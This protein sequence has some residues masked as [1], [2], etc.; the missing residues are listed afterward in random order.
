MA[1]LIVI[2]VG[3]VLANQFVLVRFPSI[4]PP[5][6]PG[7]RRQASLAVLSATTLVLALAAALAWLA[8]A[9]LL[10]PAGLLELRLLVIILSV[11]GVAAIVTPLL[12]RARQG[13]S[14]T[15]DPARS[16]VMVNAAAL[17][18]AL[19]AT[20]E[21][22]T[23]LDTLAWATGTGLGFALLMQAFAELRARLDAGT[24]PAPFRGTAIALVSA[25]IVALAFSG[26]SGIL[27]G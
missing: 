17:A 8:V 21:S 22:G 5:V 12:R 24:T 20:R 26:L 3:I 19:L 16:L 10:E 15:A 11:V 9:W 27:R 14:R 23:L 1:D 2:L 6:E 7:C 4:A 13:V 18:V 25:G